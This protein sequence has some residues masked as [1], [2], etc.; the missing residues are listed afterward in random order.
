MSWEAVT[1]IAAVVQA[2]GVVVAVAALIVQ[3]RAHQQTLK[4]TYALTGAQTAIAWRQQVLE[5]HDRGLTPAQIR[6][7]FL[8]EDGGEG[9][10]PA[11]GRIEDVLASVPPAGTRT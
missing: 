1:A 11:H 7:I 10:E 8:L 2:L 5:L 4:Q 6:V 9:Y 3:S